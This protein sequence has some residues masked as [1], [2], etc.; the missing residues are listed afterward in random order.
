LVIDTANVLSTQF[1]LRIETGE[2]STSRRVI[3][4]PAST[5]R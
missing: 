2:I 3:Q 5:T 4:D 1:G